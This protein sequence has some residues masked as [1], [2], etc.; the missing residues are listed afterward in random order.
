MA[1]PELSA[2]AETA[3]RG[4]RARFDA[5]MF[6][7]P[8]LR[9]RLF[10]LIALNVELS[11]IPEGVSEPMLGEIRLRWWADAIDTLFQNGSPEGHEVVEGLVEP[12]KAGVLDQD[13]LMTMINARRALLN[14]APIDHAALWKFLA[15]TG[16]ALAASQ[17]RALGGDDAAIEV[18]AKAGSAE[19]AGRLISAL[20][21]L[22]AQGADMLPV[23]ALF[24]RNAAL[25]GAPSSELIASVKALAEDALVTLAAAR[26]DRA[27]VPKSARAPLL[28]VR[29]Q[30]RRLRAVLA[31]DADIFTSNGAVSPFRETLSL[32]GRALIGAF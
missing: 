20:P 14:P 8:A 7:P 22:L 17:V 32:F 27:L 3:R 18:A 19:G 25:E 1:A 21:A 2:T 4:D 5:A 28:S 23:A 16:G 29:E 13:T 12:A 30:E 9:E 6:A 10:A 24:D 31:P 26:R 11:R 15:D